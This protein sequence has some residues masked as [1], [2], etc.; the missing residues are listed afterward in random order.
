MCYRPLYVTQHSSSRQ[1][2]ICHTFQTDKRSNFKVILFM[3]KLFQNLVSGQSSIFSKELC[4][5]SV[6]LVQSQISKITRGKRFALRRFTVSRNF[7]STSTAKLFHQLIHRRL[8]NIFQIATIFVAVILQE[9][10]QWRL[11]VG[12]RSSQSQLPDKIWSTRTV[13][14]SLQ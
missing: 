10:M 5:V 3:T 9:L 14:W 6:L 4:A 13:H 8:I 1:S 2:T 7:T 11:S 12:P